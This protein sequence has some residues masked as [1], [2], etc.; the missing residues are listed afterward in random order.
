MQFAINISE[1]PSA[2]FFWYSVFKDFYPQ[3]GGTWLL[4]NVG[5]HLPNYTVSQT[6]RQIFIYDIPLCFK[7]SWKD[8]R[9]V[10]HN[11]ILCQFLLLATCFSFWKHHRQASKYIHADRQFK[12]KSLKW[13]FTGGWLC[14]FTKI[15]VV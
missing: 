2:S 4:W 7:Y 3:C 13:Y 6:R 8:A 14:K 5:T 1:R 9:T 10:S 11:L 12:Y 15:G